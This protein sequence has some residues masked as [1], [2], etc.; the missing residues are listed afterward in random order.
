MHR[1]PGA[2]AVAPAVQPQRLGDLAADRAQRVERD[3]RVL[4]DEADLARRGC[5]ASRRSARPSSR[6]PS[7]LQPVGA[8]RASASP[9]EPDQGAGGDA[10][11][12]AGLADDRQALPG[13]ER[14]RDAAT[15]TASTPSRGAE[16]RTRAGSRPRTQVDGWH[17]HRLLLS[18]EP[19]LQ[20][21]GRARWRPGR[22]ATID[23]ARED[24]E[25][26]GRRDVVAAGVEQ[27][28][29]LRRRRRDA[30]PEEAEAPRPRRSTGRP[31]ASPAPRSGRTRW[32]GC[33][34]QRC[35]P[36]GGRAPSRRLDVAGAFTA[37][38]WPRTI[39]A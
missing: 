13:L 12:R 25:P 9:V 10:L 33:A 15:T 23:E 22:S 19:L 20:V 32:G 6:V 24:L 11:A 8:R 1:S 21:R 29:P 4:Q 5:R 28:A 31:R 3:Q 27:R 14:E 37:R 35:A 7:Q 30:E 39:R 16:G 17:A 36:A 34:R 2:A 18:F 26:P 38:T